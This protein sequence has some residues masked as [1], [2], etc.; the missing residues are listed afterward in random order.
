MRPS[1]EPLFWSLFSAGGTVAA[2]LIP[3]LIVMTGFLVP[4]EAVEFDRLDDLF[5]NLIVRVGL[6]GVAFFVFFH[7]AH[8]FRH[9][10][11]DLGLK[12]IAL[13][14]AVVCYLAALAGT[15]WAGFVAFG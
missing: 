10:L 15:G 9:T 12:R 2:L 5:A 13:P 6:L 11:V 4:A 8:R 7:C 14:I 3:V 1:N